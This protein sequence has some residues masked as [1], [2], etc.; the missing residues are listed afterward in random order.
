MLK[1]KYPDKAAISIGEA[2]D[3]LGV[4]RQTLTSTKGFPY[5]KVGNRYI[6]PLVALARWLS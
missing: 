1:E 4:Y 5:Q 2:S 6:V 3:L